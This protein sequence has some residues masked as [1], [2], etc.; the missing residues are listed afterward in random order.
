MDEVWKVT[1]HSNCYLFTLPSK[2]GNRRSSP[3]AYMGTRAYA[4]PYRP[5]GGDARRSLNLALIAN[6]VGK[7]HGWVP[8][9]LVLKGSAFSE[10]DLAELVHTEWYVS[11]NGSV[12]VCQPLALWTYAG[13]SAVVACL[14]GTEQ[15][16]LERW[17][18]DARRGD[19]DPSLRVE[20]GTQRLKK[21]DLAYVAGPHRFEVTGKKGKNIRVQVQ[22]IHPASS[23]YLFRGEETTSVKRSKVR[24][25]GGG[26]M[27]HASRNC[28]G[29]GQSHGGSVSYKRD[30]KK[31]RE[32][33]PLKEQTDLHKL[34]YRITGIS[35][36]KR[37]RV[38]TEVA[39]PKLGLKTVA[40]TI[41][42]HCRMR[43]AQSGGEDRYAYAI[44][45]WEHDLLRL[46]REF[47][48]H[49]SHAFTWPSAGH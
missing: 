39:M 11:P 4:V 28:A 9:E 25:G 15:K 48:D 12:K 40:S 31:P 36:A 46:K 13:G 37:W 42:N 6:P 45:E 14:R 16:P 33:L 49:G 5:V 41:A 43:R 47:Y 38:L 27:L 2:K 44:A 35:R 3:S 22:V 30:V 19:E 8:Y 26:M 21:V 29:S 32:A 23:L 10:K 34:G 7:S 18:L 1:R 20:A 24:P 17:L